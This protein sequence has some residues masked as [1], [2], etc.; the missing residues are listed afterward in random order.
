MNA[1]RFGLFLLPVYLLTS[2]CTTSE[3]FGYYVGELTE[4]SIK[5]LFA[6]A[7]N[8]V[9][10]RDLVTYKSL[11]GPTYTTV[12]DLQD[13]PG[14]SQMAY[15]S[16]SRSEY[17]SLVDDVFRRAKKLELYTMVME[18]EMLEPGALALVT[19]QEDEFIDINGIDDRVVSLLRYQVA[20]EDGWI[21][22]KKSTRFARQEIKE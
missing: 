19:V 15:N 16:L 21:F 11:F 2:S 17:F 9:N 1:L 5:A 10:E 20:L 12:E 22:F 6:E 3:G 13:S 14:Y 18:I 8:A 4:E 7:D